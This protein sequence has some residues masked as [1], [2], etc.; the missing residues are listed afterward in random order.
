[1]KRI[2]TFEY[3]KVRYTDIFGNEFSIDSIAFKKFI[4]NIE[5]KYKECIK[6][7]YD[8]III[9]NFVGVIKINQCIIEVMPKIF[10]NTLNEIDKS[11]IYNNLYYMLNKA[12][13]VKYKNIT[14]EQFN[15]IHVSILDYYINIFLEEL[16]NKTRPNMYHAY[17]SKV[18]NRKSI[19]GKILISK[20]FRKNFYNKSK[21]ICKYE[22]FTENNI[23][24]Q[25]L[26]FTINKMLKVTKW[27]K[28]KKICKDLLARMSEVDNI[29]VTNDTFSKIK[30]DNNLYHLEKILSTA[31][32]FIN[33]LF[34][35][36][37]NANKQDIFIFNFDMNFL[38]QEYI[39]CLIDENKEYIF[40]NNSKVLRQTG[41]KYLMYE[42]GIG[43]LKLIPDIIIEEDKK[44]KYIID[45]KYKILDADKMSARV[46][47]DDLFQMNAYIDRYDSQKAI[48]LYPQEINKYRDKYSL[49]KEEENKIL[50]CTVNLK[51]DLIKEEKEVIDE[52][53]EIILVQ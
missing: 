1:M 53:K 29:F 33:N 36:F 3:S 27:S 2:I 12:N 41:R 18:E 26:K 14:T 28:N 20:N 32:M 50:V 42:K 13:K 34:T 51:K 24:N 40:K 30:Y 4:K 39:Y 8:S 46:A 23:V 43:K 11:T 38:F 45:T 48:L 15:R 19:K 31:Q 35:S 52:I 21:N 5:K 47:R 7:S 37:E 25:I 6:L 49:A 44:A 10:A 22:E 9:T 16:N 17:E